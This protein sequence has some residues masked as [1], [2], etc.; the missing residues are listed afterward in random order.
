MAEAGCK[1]GRVAW[2]IAV[3]TI[4]FAPTAATSRLAAQEA[5]SG[6]MLLEARRPGAT[7]RVHT[8]LKAK[9]LY[10]PAAP[11]GEAKMPKPL[12]AEIETRFI[13]YERLVEVDSRGVARLARVGQPSAVPVQTEQRGVLK[14]V[15][16]SMEAGLAVNGEVRTISALLRPEVRLLIAGRPENDGPVVVFSP[17]GPLTWDELQLVQGLGDPLTL[18]DLL[19]GQPVAIGGHWPIRSGGARALSEYDAITKNTLDA[20]LETADATKARIRLTGQ[21][22]GS[23][24]GAPGKMSCDGFFTFDRQAALIDHLD[25]N[26]IENRQPGPIEAGL[27]Y[28]STLTIN[29]QAAEPPRTLAD[30]SLAGLSLQITPQRELLKLDLP[31]GKATLLHDRNWDKFWVDRKLIVL[32]RLSGNQ[33][34]AQCNLM[35]GPNAG[36]GRH[37]DPAQFRDDIRRALKQRFVR[38]IGAGEVDGHPSGGFRYKVAVS[39]REGELGIVWY[40]YLLA[41]P[42]GE[43]LLATFTLAQDHVNTFGDQDLEMIGSLVWN[44]KKPLELES[45]D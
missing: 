10:R 38:F 16:Q 7:T 35:L 14:A 8:A 41:S 29:R 43:Q 21:I 5:A 2:M 12:A 37:Q 42:E 34:I 19:P 31:G 1:I 45:R 4:L 22:E 24:Q 36:K 6:I 28:K 20:W 3:A 9:G 15:R 13:F 17:A 33:V 26:R 32:K 23:K 40:Y 18:G 27:E 44:P 25:L 11:P 30:A 39:G